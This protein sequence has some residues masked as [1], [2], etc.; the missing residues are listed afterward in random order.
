MAQTS[1]FARWSDHRLSRLELIFAIIVILVLLSI[2]LN[3]MIILMAR[4][5]RT[6]VENSIVN[7]NSTIRMYWLQHSLENN[8][9]KI[10]NMH[11]ANPIKLLEQVSPQGENNDFKSPQLAA[12]LEARSGVRPHNYVGELMTGDAKE[13]EPGSWYFEIDSNALVYLVRN[14][15]VFRSELPGQAK[16]RFQL[17]LAYTDLDQDGRYTP[18][19]DNINHISMQAMDEYKW[20]F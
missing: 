11:H 12:L 14:K 7:I 2:F 17:E 13:M 20:L 18:N 1:L 10:N 8:H 19:I 15:A 16:M 9:E 5:E 6:L 4:A 3:Q